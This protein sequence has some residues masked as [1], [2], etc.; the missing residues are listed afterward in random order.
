MIVKDRLA[1]AKNCIGILYKLRTGIEKPK[2]IDSD[3]VLRGAIER[4]LHLAIEAIIDVGMRLASLLRLG[5]PER[6]RDIAKM[7]RD[8][9]ILD[10]DEV[11]K[12]ELWI[13]LRNIL[14]HGYAEIDYEKLYEALN[15]VEELEH[16]I[17]KIYKY[18]ADK[19]IDP[20]TNGCENLV[21]RAREV[22]EKRSDIV[23]AYVFGSRATDGYGDRSDIDI[24]IY[25]ESPL[26]WREFVELALE[27]EDN[28]GIKVD[29]VDL[30][31]APLLLAYEIISNGVV[32]VDRDREKRLEFE[33]KILR[34]YLDL[35][36]RLERYYSDIL[37]S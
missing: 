32:I 33:A 35:K 14:V 37:S 12:L 1:F 5:K 15:E 11:R 34:E 18:V 31:T 9:R 3:L 4:Y 13:D 29:L 24:A 25:T 2:G 23:F 26:K 30:R 10:G 28:L 21:A 27:L 20:K 7:L 19:N 36:P 8:C 17:N 22:L 6:Y 16:L